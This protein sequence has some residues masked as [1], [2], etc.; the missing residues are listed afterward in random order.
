M[1]DVLT[2]QTDDAVAVLDR[3]LGKLLEFLLNAS[4]RLGIVDS[5]RDADLRGGD[6]IDRRLMPIKNLEYAVKKPVR[7]QHARRVDIHQRN[8]LLAGN[9][10]HY[11]RRMYMAG[12]DPRA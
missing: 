6:H 12:D 5:Q 9:R 7:H 3:N 2:H 4:E 11:I 8:V 10:L 1:P